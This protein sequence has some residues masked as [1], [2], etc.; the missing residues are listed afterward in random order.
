MRVLQAAALATGLAATAAAAGGIFNLPESAPPDRFGT[1]LINRQASTGACEPVVFSHWRHRAKFSCRVCHYELEFQLLTN[2]TEITEADNRHGLFCGACHDG[3]EAFS[4]TD[5]ARCKTCHAGKINAEKKAFKAFSK[6]LPKAPYGNEVDWVQALEIL[7]PRYAL[8]KDEKPMHFDKDLVLRTDWNHVP[9][10]V[11]PHPVHAQFLDC[12]N[13]HPD[14]FNIKKN[15]TKNF[16][17]RF[18]LE[19]KFCGACHLTVAF[20]LDDCIRCHT[21][22]HRN[23]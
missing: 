18:I 2:A 21:G 20:P 14:V 22:M 1:V 19:R 4:V 23:M 7:K 12:A 17:M 15:T 8:Y 16:G 5:E 11:F 3:G 6:K 13:C 9:Q 10:A